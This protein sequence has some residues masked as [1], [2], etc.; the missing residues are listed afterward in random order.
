MSATI[1]IFAALT[2]AGRAAVDS[3][4]GQDTRTRSAPASSTRRI[5]SMVAA[6]SAVSVLVMVWTVIGASPPTSTDADADFPARASLNHPPG[7]N[8]GESG[9]VMGVHGEIIP[10]TVRYIV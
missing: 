6:A 4:S 3:S 7:A 8:V 1:G 9:V 2:M 5:C 10:E